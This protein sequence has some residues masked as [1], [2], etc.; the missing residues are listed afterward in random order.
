MRLHRPLAR[1]R[2]RLRLQA[3]LEGGALAAVVAAALLVV[4]VYLWRLHVFG[5]RGL[6]AVGL[7]AAGLVLAGV[8]ARA[9]ARIPLERAALQI[10]QSHGLHDRVRSALAFGAEPAPTPFM[11][12]A[13]ADA[14]AA[15]ERVDA[16]RAAPLSRPAELTA[17]AILFAV[18]GVV[19]LLHFP[20]RAFAR[21][22]AGAAAAPRRRSRPARARRAGGARARERPPSS[23][24]TSDAAAAGRTSSTSC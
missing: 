1:V 10:D 17:A 4:G 15:A 21:G 14:E 13:V 24:A 3:A 2:R 6:L 8:V 23:P 19:A 22:G 20:A 5:G 18:A 7:A 9:V 11:Q 12:A 16:R